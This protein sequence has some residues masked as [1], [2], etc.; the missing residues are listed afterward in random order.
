MK[1]TVRHLHRALCSAALGLL[2]LGRAGDAEAALTDSEK[3][4][5]VGYVRDAEVA[6]AQRVR[7][8]IARPDLT[9]E[10]S[11]A[12]LSAAYGPVAFDKAREAFSLEL[13]H[14]SGSEPS[15]G[16]VAEAIV[17]GLLARADAVVAKL[18]AARG[19]AISD[20]AR[21]AAIEFTRIHSFVASHIANAGQP[22][23]DGHDASVGI[24]DDS[25]KRAS[26]AYVKHFEKHASWM[27]LSKPA[28]GYWLRARGQAAITLAS[29][30]RGVVPRHEVAAA[31]GLDGARRAAFERH[32]FI[33][34]DAGLTDPKRR[35][36]FVRWLDGC[37]RAADG[38]DLVLLSKTPSYGLAALGRVVRVGVDPMTERRVDGL[39]AEDVQPVG[40]DAATSE[41]AYLM[42]WQAVRSAFAK[43][44]ELRKQAELLAGR[45]VKGGD[46]FLLSPELGASVLASPGSTEAVLRGVSPEMFLAHVVRLALLDLPRVRS[47]ALARSLRGNT[48]GV[49]QLLLALSALAPGTDAKQKTWAGEALQNGRVRGL[50]VAL[51]LEKGNVSSFSVGKTR[52]TAK[53]LGDGRVDKI[54]LN[55]KA[56]ALPALPYARLVP[57]ATERWKFGAQ[58]LE[59]LSGAPRGLV[60]GDGR[61]VLA[62]AK[63]SQGF[64]AV[65]FGAA[66]ENAVVSAKLSPN[67]PGGGLLVRAQ[68]GSAGYDAIGLFVS[69]E[70]KVAQLVVVGG[71]GKAVELTGPI[72]LPS[73]D[74]NFDVRLEVKGKEVRG[75]VGRQKLKATLSRGV[76]KGRAG[77]AV[78]VGGR[79]EIRKLSVKR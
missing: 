40:M 29:L 37:P 55:G 73:K 59:K 22:P 57:E 27:R 20:S 16:V 33:L 62:A 6:R 42:A 14:G 47:L 34:D 70:P 30:A 15:R 17:H 1:R 67:G 4:Q 50:E 53:L 54:L 61:F 78:R 32:G 49:A 44:P 12:P 10:E 9:Q 60:V 72:A 31:L 74:T 66:A 35:D 63:K 21:P 5:I 36:L 77:I 19:P 28:R 43:R 75:R 13:L 56:P 7:A 71:S 24:R 69:A 18:S 2:L 38:L 48:D 11:S 41:L 51:Q 23:A 46:H 68:K 76:G 79:L 65:A 39:W 25:M 58:V 45:A 8:L 26:G 52:V 64:D 3:R